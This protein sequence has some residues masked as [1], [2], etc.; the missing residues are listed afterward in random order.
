MRNSGDPCTEVGVDPPP[1]L[2]K[3][4]QPG[5]ASSPVSSYGRRPAVLSVYNR[6]SVPGIYNYGRKC[7]ERW[8]MNMKNIYSSYFRP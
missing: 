6:S 2:E 5:P 1:I 8:I 4:I 3:E 7:E